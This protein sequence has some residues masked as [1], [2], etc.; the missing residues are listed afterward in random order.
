MDQSTSKGASSG[1]L[2]SRSGCLTIVDTF[3]GSLCVIDVQPRNFSEG[4]ISI[5]NKFAGLIIDELE[6]RTLAHRDSLTGA[7]TRRSF[8]EDGEKAISR[9][10]RYGRPCALILF[11]LD[12]FKQINDGF[13]HPAGDEV[14]K[15]IADCCRATLRPADIL[16]R[17]GGEEF[18]VLLN[19]TSLKDA[20]A[21]AERLR[22][23]FPR[24]AFDWAPH[25]RITASFGVSEIGAGHSL[26]HCIS[27]TDAA[28][29][30]AKRGGRNRTISSNKL[31]SCA[32]AA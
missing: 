12:H 21:F 8:I 18:G 10:D 1:R 20:I 22:T 2:N 26:D 17:L 5:L 32:V 28:L 11:D 16:G 13:G 25:L 19:E 27:V 7:A 23:Q 4:Q 15:A 29:F 30:K 9:L 14:L 24:L 3:R 31:E 6:L